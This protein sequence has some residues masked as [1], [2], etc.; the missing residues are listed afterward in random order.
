MSQTSPIVLFEL[1][2]CQ[3]CRHH[4]RLL[5]HHSLRH[6]YLRART[7]IRPNFL[8]LVIDG[9][10]DQ[11]HLLTRGHA[12]KPYTSMASLQTAALRM[13]TRDESSTRKPQ[14]TD[15]A[16]DAVALA[17]GREPGHGRAG[18]GPGRG[19]RSKSSRHCH[20][21]DYTGNWGAHCRQR[22]TPKNQHRSG[23][24]NPMDES[25][26]YAQDHDDIPDINPLNLNAFVARP[27][28]PTAYL[29]IWDTGCTSRARRL[30]Y[31]TFAGLTQKLG[32]C[33]MAGRNACQF[34]GQAPL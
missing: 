31:M 8:E 10:T 4:L 12:L 17:G 3:R 33:S 28:L 5:R 24:Q 7:L 15:Q 26:H 27:A 34:W 29:P 11:F 2:V 1:R 14:I 18:R 22:T 21:C 30:R 16:N 6:L 32:T 23:L 13:E 9:L 19:G 20:V 25:A